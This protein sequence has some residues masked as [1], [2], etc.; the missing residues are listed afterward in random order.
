V[1]AERPD[2]DGGALQERLRAAVRDVSNFPQAG[3]TFKDIT[4]VLADAPLFAA[5]VQ[6]LASFASGADLVV[7]IE[8]R[9]FIFGAPLAIGLGCGFVPFR[10]PGKL[11][12]RTERIAYGLEYGSD[13]L[14]AHVDAIVPGHRVLI[15]DDV[16]ATGGTAAAAAALVTRLGGVVV[17]AAF[18]LE[19]AALGGRGRLGTVPVHTLLAYD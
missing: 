13:A 1:A 9:G 2:R 16:L 14:E 4:P 11:P 3:I 10:K 12:F 19:L 5:V 15:V 17:G 6:A 8:S 18:V 7:G